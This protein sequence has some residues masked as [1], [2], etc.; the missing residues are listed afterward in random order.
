MTLVTKPLPHIQHRIQF[1]RPLRLS[2][3]PVLPFRRSY[4]SAS[5]SNVPSRAAVGT[6]PTGPQAE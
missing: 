6:R 5:P 1:Q 3:L 4:R 2:L